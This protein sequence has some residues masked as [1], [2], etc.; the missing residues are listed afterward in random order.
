M[1][2]LII[3][4]T[5]VLTLVISGVNTV[6]AQPTKKLISTKAILDETKSFSLEAS[7]LKYNGQHQLSKATFFT[8]FLAGNSIATRKSFSNQTPIQLIGR[9]RAESKDIGVKA[10]IIVVAIYNNT[11]FVKSPNGWKLWN[12]QLDNLVAIKPPSPLQI[13]EDVDILASFSMQGSF[14]IFLGY[15]VNGDLHYTKQGIDFNIY[16]GLV[17]ETQAIQLSTNNPS[18]S[19]NFSGQFSRNNHILGGNSFKAEKGIDIFGRININAENIGKTG[20]ILRFA[21]YQGNWYMKTFTGWTPWDNKLNSLVSAEVPRAFKPIEDI[22]IERNLRLAGDYEFFFGYRI[23]NQFYYN[24]KPLMLSIL[25]N[26]ALDDTNTPSL[27]LKTITPPE[28]IIATAQSEAIQLTWDAVENAALYNLYYSLDPSF[29]T[30]RTKQKNNIH[31]PYTL[32]GLNNGQTYY[33]ALTA[34]N[35]GGEKSDFSNAMNATPAPATLITPPQNIVATANNESIQLTWDAVENVELY[36]LYYSLDPSFPT[37]QT[38]QKNNIHS[39]YTLTGLN[40]GQTYYLAL[41]AENINREESNFSNEVSSSP[42][43]NKNT[44]KLNDTGITWG[45]I[46]PEGKNSTCTG[47]SINAQD[48]SYGR[49]VTHNN[50]SDGHAGFSFTKVDKNGN[51]LPSSAGVWSCVRDNVTGLIWEAKTD[52]GDIHDKDNTHRWG[53]WDTLVNGSNAESL[54]GFSD[55]HV[56]TIKQ[57]GSLIIYSQP[58]GIAIDMNYFPYATLY[59]NT[60]NTTN[61]WSSSLYYNGTSAWSTVYAGGGISSHIPRSG[62]ANVMLVRGEQ[63]TPTDRFQIHANGTVTD[64]KTNLMWKRCLEGMSGSSCTGSSFYGHWEQALQLSDSSYAGYND[65]RVPNIKELQSIVEEQYHSPA[66]NTAIFP[67]GAY[68]GS[69]PRKTWSSSPGGISNHALGVSFEFGLIKSYPRHNPQI[70]GLN[71]RLVRSIQ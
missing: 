46:Y 33:L 42:I 59:Y 61:F 28:N 6:Y 2:K 70:S 45:A 20:E 4:Y 71:V 58:Y 65:W 31:S 60:N 50:D 47:S 12:G 8:Q 14:K 38:E 63:S 24:D 69:H 57:L 3:N 36:N 44:S 54:C 30:G 64:K 66:L 35:I 40:N 27:P 13:V 56:P 22:E 10:E 53:D 41:T 55:W 48:C 5:T 62:S 51:N 52:A 32:T 68:L 29:P 67:S 15:R 17:D 39:P 7:N 23:N 26:P 16:N 11:L 37:A 18:S 43:P 1:L 34:E 9:I 19:V 25:D 49:D 21:T